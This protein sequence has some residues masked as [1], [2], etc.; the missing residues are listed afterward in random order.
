M[1]PSRDGGP[2]AVS[3]AMV[4]DPPSS[5]GHKV[6]LRQ[7]PSPGFAIAY[8]IVYILKVVYEFRW[9]QWNVEH[10]AEHGVSA[11]DA[12]RVVN[13]PARGFPRFLGDGRYLVQGAVTGGQYI[14]V[15]YIFSPAGVVYVIHA[16]PLTDAE[17]RRFRRGR[18]R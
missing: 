4:R 5:G 1:P 12:E 3:H 2:Q 15:I 8:R 11:N 17:K 6:V 16:R 7:C 14:Q 18:R 13:S 9:N 10:I